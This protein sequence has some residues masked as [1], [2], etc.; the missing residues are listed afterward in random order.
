[1]RQ[2]AVS[3]VICKVQIRKTNSGLVYDDA[4]KHLGNARLSVTEEDL[5]LT[6]GTVVGWSRLLGLAERWGR[7]KGLRRRPKH[8]S[9]KHREYC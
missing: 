4:N 9:L 7:D 5:L 2:G 1:M 6:W 3:M 8:A